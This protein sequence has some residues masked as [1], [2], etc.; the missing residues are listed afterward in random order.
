MKKLFA[1]AAFFL[2]LGIPLL[3]QTNDVGSLKNGVFSDA[4]L[5]FRYTP[6]KGL[7]D[8]TSDA[9]ES[10]QERAAALHTSNTMEVLLRMISG[11]DDTAP[12]WHSV[13]IET[14][15]RSKFSSLSD[16][17]SEEKM[18]QWV[19]AGA[20]ANPVGR[21]EELS[22]AGA[23]FVVSNVERS[24]PPLV[25]HGR[26]YSTI[27][28]GKLIAF[29]F[30][31]N[32]PDKIV[33]IAESLQTLEFAGESP[34]SYL[35]FDRNE[36]PGDGNLQE[37]HKIFTY[38]G[39]WLN[40]PPGARTNT[41]AG[42]RS[43]LGAAGFG[44]LVLFNGRLHQE[45]GT[46]A[47]ELG[48]ADA[49]A[50][51]AA[52]KR[53][54]FPAHTV[55]FLDQEEGGRLLPDQKTYLFAWVDGI[56]QAGFRAGVYCSGVAFQEKGGASVI[57]AEDIRQSSG[58]RDIAYW[59]TNDG[60]PPSPGCAV[61]RRPP[62]PDASGVKFADVWQFAQSPRRKDVAMACAGYNSDGNCY[63]AGA[64]AQQPIHLDLNSASFADPSRGRTH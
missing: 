5:G 27:R 60:C 41:W 4:E 13:G 26:I 39:Y 24:E 44:F 64:S 6:P 59:V 20:G 31:A 15:L 48:K 46:N 37:L 53:E 56:S 63:A 12:D 58:K 32:S 19:A 3:S 21:P 33:L 7:T 22:I 30:S 16:A 18:N 25:K 51:V 45:L 36:Y 17:A 11:P 29:A 50:A 43:K 61:P 49:L 42:K 8:E 47:A 54:G 38:A 10:V 55:I 57:T 9:R 28:N 62:S 2:L 1:F 40:N 52:A 34:V 23:H 14:Y 35:G